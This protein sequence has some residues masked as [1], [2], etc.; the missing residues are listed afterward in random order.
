M[1]TLNKI[2]ELQTKYELQV[3]AKKRFGQNFLIDQNVLEH[4]IEVADIKGKDVVEVGPGMGSL[5]VFLLPE[6][7]KL[8]AYE[9]DKDMITVLN[10]EI[11]DENFE[12]IDGDFLKQPLE[13]EGKKT[14]VA[15]LPYYITSDI[16]FRL[17]ENVEKFDKAVI[18][19]Q[20]EVAD[21]L[22][23][24]VGS[25]QYGKLT[26]STNYYATVK[27][28]FVVKP[29]SFSPAPRVNSAIVSLTFNKTQDLDN[30]AFLEF[31]KKSFTQRRKTL[32]NNWKLIMGPEAAKELILEM[33]LKESVR[34]QELTNK[35]FEE[36][37]LK[38]TK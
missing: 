2:K 20:D 12:L 27:K 19:I 36:A 30:K 13:W 21:R 6:A 5:T 35:Q 38:F 29:S 4:I 28:E 7:K 31:V 14:L 22:S 32:F 37:F 25:K 8:T 24:P 11:K 26:I 33:G 23:A 9:I 34:P 15:N 3:H 17:F 1:L 16:L 10:G 18:M